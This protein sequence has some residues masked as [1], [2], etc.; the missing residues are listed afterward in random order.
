MIKLRLPI[1]ALLGALG[2]LG[3]SMAFAQNY[4]CD[5]SVV[6]QGGGEMSSTNYRAGTTVG[7]TA[8]GLTAS[9]AYQSFIGFWQID[10]AGTGIQE[11]K[12]WQQGNPLTTMLYAP[13]PNPCVGPATIRYSLAAESHVTLRLFDLSGRCL[14]TLMDCTQKPGR[15]SSFILQRS[16]VGGQ[17]SA[18][19]SGVYFLKM[20]TGDYQA[21]RKLVIE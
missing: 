21:T 5:W 9:T 17:R 8:I 15:Y 6:G 11:E 18:L 2:V 20:K 16:A 3:G 7:Q 13:A 12:P 10:T 14:R 1:L 19:S 4:R